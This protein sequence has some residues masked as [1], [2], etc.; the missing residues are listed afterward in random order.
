MVET[1]FEN[2]HQWVKLL[3]FKRIGTMHKF[4]CDGRDFDL[5]ERIR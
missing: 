2:G 3:G 4:A 1:P 5:Y